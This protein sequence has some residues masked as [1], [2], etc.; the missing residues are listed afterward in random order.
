MSS[1][2]P[3]APQIFQLQAERMYHYERRVSQESGHIVAV[4]QKTPPRCAALDV[5]RVSES[6]PA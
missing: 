5:T 4:S 1:I 3:P 6:P 2:H